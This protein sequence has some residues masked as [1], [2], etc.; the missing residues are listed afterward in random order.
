MSHAFI[1]VITI[2]LY[3]PMSHSL[4]DKRKQIKSLKDKLRSRFNVSIAETGMQD[5]WQQSQIS[6]VMIGAD[7][8]YLEEQASALQNLVLE[9]RE[10]EITNFIT[11]WL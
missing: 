9:Y 11:N 5:A 8:R 1:C 7:K 3:V 6:A 4:K 2:E 10:I